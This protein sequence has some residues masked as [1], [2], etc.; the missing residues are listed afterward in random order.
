MRLPT[1]RPYAALIAWASLTLMFAT[2]P[3]NATGPRSYRA[4]AARSATGAPKVPV[5]T[6]A[7][8]SAVPPYQNDPPIFT[9]GRA[10]SSRPVTDG[11]A[12]LAWRP[13][14]RPSRIPSPADRPSARSPFTRYTRYASPLLPGMVP[15]APSQIGRAHV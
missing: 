5:P 7:F 3:R 10:H 1:E 13:S 6:A 4:S 12:K 14:W 2:T 15:T 9:P 8:V 11:F